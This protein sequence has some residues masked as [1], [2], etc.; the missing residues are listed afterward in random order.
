MNQ[1]FP[2][3]SKLIEPYRVDYGKNFRLKDFDPAD[4]HGLDLKEEAEA[5]LKQGIERLNDM[6]QKLYAQDRWALLVILQGMD[7]VGKD[8][9]IRHAMS[10]INPTTCQVFA[11]KA[12]SAEELNHHFL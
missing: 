3:I 5:F 4:T 12:P 11:F 7:A 10:G 1:K 9:I 2:K 8:G 6:Q